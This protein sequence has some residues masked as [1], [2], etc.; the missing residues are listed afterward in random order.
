MGTKEQVAVLAPGVDPF[1]EA[2]FAFTSAW[3][4]A[5]FGT[6]GW[7]DCIRDDRLFKYIVDSK[8]G[9][10]AGSGRGGFGCAR[11]F[12]PG[13]DGPGLQREG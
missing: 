4:E 2:V 6:T 7:A 1:F 5:K 9:K 3:V 13:T 8:F 10:G 12:E 11:F